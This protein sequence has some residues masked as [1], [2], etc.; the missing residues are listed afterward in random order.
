MTRRTHRLTLG[1]ARTR[2]QAPD[3]M[4]CLPE[5]LQTLVGISVFDLPT[6]FVGRLTEQV[7]YEYHFDSDEVAKAV[8]YAIDGSDFALAEK[9]G[10]RASYD[11]QILDREAYAH[12]VRMMRISCLRRWRSR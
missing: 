4:D 3:A 11:I 7:L 9:Y 8:I 1:E 12:F 6:K 10:D 5:H 2:A